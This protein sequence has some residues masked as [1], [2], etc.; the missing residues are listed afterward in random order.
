M[1][2]CAKPRADGGLGKMLIPLIADVNKDVGR[3]Y[4]V[5]CDK[6]DEKGVAYRATFIIDKEGVLRHYS[7]NDLPVGRNVDETLRLVK[8]F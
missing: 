5:I 3:A 4:G 2:Y 8:A 6:G 1:E 7:I